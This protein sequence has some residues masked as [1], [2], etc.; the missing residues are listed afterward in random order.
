MT[1]SPS[2]QPE[3]AAV[4][5]ADEL[6]ALVIGGGVAGIYALYCLQQLGIRVQMAE[7]GAGVGGAWFWNRYPGARF[8]SDSISYGYFFSDVLAEEWQW[9]EHFAGQEEVERYFNFVVDRFDLRK[10]ICLN[11][12]VVSTRFDEKSD[13]WL[14][15]LADGRQVATRYVVAATGMLSQPYVPPF[16]GLD[17]FTGTLVHTG[18]W[19]AEGVDVAG[20]RVAVIGT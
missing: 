3:G 15:E 19:P 4:P 10:N 2:T 17:D 12:E 18:T 9:S 1:N 7:R 6:D 11:A 14:V 8:D 13:R 16:A 20:K 5:L